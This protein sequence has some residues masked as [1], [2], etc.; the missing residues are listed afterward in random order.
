M[1]FVEST[2]CLAVM[3]TAHHCSHDHRYF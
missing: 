3:L 2:W 1:L